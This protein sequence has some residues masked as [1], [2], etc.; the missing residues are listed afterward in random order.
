MHG[1]QEETWRG[2]WRAEVKSGSGVNPLLT[3]W[4]AIQAQAEAAR[5][6][7]D[8]RPLCGVLVPSGR[9]VGEPVVLV[10]L[11]DWTAL[12]STL[13]STNAAQ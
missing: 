9:H 6:P 7:D 11:S 10:S 1:S 8:K 12:L 3:R 2:S 4:R 5:A 13:E